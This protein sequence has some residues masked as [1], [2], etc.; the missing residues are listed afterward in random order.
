MMITDGI[1]FD[2]DG[3]FWDSTDVVK[4]AWNQALLDTGY[5]VFD[6]TADRLKGLFGLPMYDIL[7]DLMPE[8]EVSDLDKLSPFVFSYEHDYIDKNPPT[9][10]EGVPQMIRTL[11]KRVPL[12]VVSN[13]Q[14]GYIELFCKKTGLGEY[15]KGHLCPG[16]TNLLKADNIRKIVADFG[17]KHPVYVGDTSMDEKACRDAECPFIWASYGFGKATAPDG[18]I[19]KPMDLVGLVECI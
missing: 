3:T 1:I 16:D 5:G 18:V 17:L 14:A 13:C 2:V 7:K 19:E 15:F 10:Y 4:D 6:I 8:A 9:P 12:F 11:A